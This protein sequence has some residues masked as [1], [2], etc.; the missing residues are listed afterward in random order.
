M[1]VCVCVS[2]MYHDAPVEVRGQLLG[3]SCL[4]LWV[5]GMELRSPGYNKHLY[6]LG[7]HKSP[8]ILDLD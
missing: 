4:L 5:L 2:V 3:V 1:Y 8:L 6:L 7:C